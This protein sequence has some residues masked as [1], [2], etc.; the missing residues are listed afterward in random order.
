MTSPANGAL[1]TTQQSKSMQRYHEFCRI[2]QDCPNFA[3]DRLQAW[4]VGT[5]LKIKVWGPLDELARTGTFV[6]A[7]TLRV[8]DMAN[9]EHR[10]S[11][12]CKESKGL[13]E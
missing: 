5:D 2:L 10:R 7:T 1:E 6:T 9:I 4:P 3:A 8:C 11:M 12:E 13:E